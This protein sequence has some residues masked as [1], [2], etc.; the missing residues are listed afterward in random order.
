M[1]FTYTVRNWLGSV[2]IIVVFAELLPEYAVEKD[3]MLDEGVS[4]LITR[5]LKAE[6]P[7]SNLMRSRICQAISTPL[8]NRWVL[9]VTSSQHSSRPK[10]S[11]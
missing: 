7:N 1:N 9:P 10:A 2:C 6:T 8:P 3:D 11:T 5:Y 4:V